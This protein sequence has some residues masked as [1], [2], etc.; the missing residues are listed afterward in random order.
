[1]KLNSDEFDILKIY[2]TENQ[3]TTVYN[4]EIATSFFRDSPHGYLFRMLLNKTK[5]MTKDEFAYYV[6]ITKKT[7]QDFYEQ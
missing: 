4:L 1:M 6:N 2:I 7:I 3:T 5:G